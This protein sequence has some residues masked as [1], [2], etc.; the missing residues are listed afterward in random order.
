MESWVIECIVSGGVTGYRCAL[1][2]EG[3]H[4]WIGTKD[5]ATR[6]AAELMQSMNNSR[7]RATFQYTAVVA[8]RYVADSIRAGHI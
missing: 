2:K 7:S 1:L 6:K 3:D 4:V 5:E 8:S